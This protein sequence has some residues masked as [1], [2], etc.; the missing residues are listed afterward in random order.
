M[1]K[2]LSR[3]V[4]S[5]E[6]SATITD[7]G[8]GEELTATFVDITDEQ[9]EELAEL[10]EQAGESEEAATEYQK[11]IINDYNKDDIEYGDCGPALR[12]SIIAGFMRAIGGESAVRDAEEFFEAVNQGNR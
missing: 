12:Q 3:D 10:E 4:I 1:A 9:R 8:S 2:Q 11:S 5:G 7:P 6:V